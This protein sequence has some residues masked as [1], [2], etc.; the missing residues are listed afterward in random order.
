M[1][2]VRCVAKRYQFKAGKARTPLDM[3]N[4]QVVPTMEAMADAMKSL[5]SPEAGALLL[6]TAKYYWS[7]TQFQLTGVMMEQA[8]VDRWMTLLREMLVKPLPEGDS[9]LEPLGQPKDPLARE[10]WVWWK[11]KKWVLHIA[12]RMLHRYGIPSHAPKTHKAVRVPQ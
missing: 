8:R 9:D 12:S 3:F 6:L 11:I 2:F 4:A 1:Y 10:G 5:N 7:A